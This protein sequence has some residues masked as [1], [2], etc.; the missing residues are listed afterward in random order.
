M[1]TKLP[2]KGDETKEQA[3]NNLERNMEAQSA[4]K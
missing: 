2:K 4:C 1:N 3:N